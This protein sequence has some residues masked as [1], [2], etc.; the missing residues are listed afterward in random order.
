MFTITRGKGFHITFENGW[1][2]S[3]QWGPGNYCDHRYTAFDSPDDTRIMPQF[4]ESKTAEV[5]AFKDRDK[6]YIFPGDEG[7]T[8]SVKG[9][10][11]PKEVLEFMVMIAN[12]P[13]SIT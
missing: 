12:I 3:V 11:T 1:T 9:Y 5:A 6:W 13:T 8:T 7:L 2:V 10:M 4:W